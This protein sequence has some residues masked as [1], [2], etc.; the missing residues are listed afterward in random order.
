M[1]EW[2]GQRYWIVGA[3]EG[4]GRA[5]A[6]VMSR[7]AA[8]LVLS[9]RNEERLRDLAADLPGRARAVPC[10]V[11]DRGSV[12]QAAAE[13]GEIDGLVYMPAVYW[14]MTARDWDPDRAE[15]MAD[16]N[17]TGCLRVLG[18]VVPKML[19]RGRGHIV[20]VGSLSGR[21]GLPGSV[22]YGA[23]K[24][25]I[26]NL[27]EGMRSDL[28]E[29]GVEVQLVNPGFVRTR[30]TDRNDFR[31]PGIMEPERAAREIFEHMNRD[32]FAHD[33]PLWFSLAFAMGRILPQGMWQRLFR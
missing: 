1:R 26:I 28:A 11:A 33:F 15:A 13:A 17:F 4:L 7:S 12:A 31:M 9:A 19:E 14:P 6:G 8:E 24:A 29:T 10:D 23:S 21:R 27:A 18:H 25:A 32:G 5:L 16:V 20:L 30:L 22:G 3:S 2:P